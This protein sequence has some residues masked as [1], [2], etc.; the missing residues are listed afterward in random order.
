MLRA[1]PL[2][3]FAASCARP[4]LTPPGTS[5]ER[6]DRRGLFHECIAQLAERGVAVVPPPALVSSEK[7]I[8][9]GAYEPLPRR[10]VVP[11]RSS[12]ESGVRL[13]Q[14]ASE[15]MTGGRWDWRPHAE[16]RRTATL[17][18]RF[19][20]LGLIYQ[21]VL[22]HLQFAGLLRPGSLDEERR[23]DAERLAS[24]AR[25]AFL[26][27]YAEKVD[28]RLFPLYQRYEQIFR[29][30]S[31]ELDPQLARLASKRGEAARRYWREQGRWML[32]ARSGQRVRAAFYISWAVEDFGSVDAT[33]HVRE[34]AELKLHR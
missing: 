33:T 30:L 31:A 32:N 24:R 26:R 18:Y 23:Y 6:L 10:V 3:L 34:L 27:Y 25:I 28:P 11:P 16:P 22:H 7:H 15:L 8:G 1:F 5:L 12:P 9:L 21:G 20:V 29:A 17:L 19:H 2:L 4:G 14:L 13:L